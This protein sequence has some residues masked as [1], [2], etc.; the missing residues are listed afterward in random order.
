L[1]LIPVKVG[2]GKFQPYGRFTSVQPN[3]SSKRE[4]IEGGVN[5]IID[6]FNARISAY[7]QHG[8]LFTKGLNY[9]PGVTGEK[10][11]IFKLS[12]QIQM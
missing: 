4:E 1:Y 12:F 11:D 6:G 10:V 8:D 2:I 3:N 9:A 5:Y 7:Y